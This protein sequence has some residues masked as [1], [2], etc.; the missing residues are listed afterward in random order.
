MEFII[1]VSDQMQPDGSQRIEESRELVRCRNCK[2][3]DR[4]EISEG[5]KGNPEWFCANAEKAEF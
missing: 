5:C 1:R 3:H 4:C 2:H